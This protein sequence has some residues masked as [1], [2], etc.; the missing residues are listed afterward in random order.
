[1]RGVKRTP[2]EYEQFEELMDQAAYWMIWIG[3]FSSLLANLSNPAS[4]AAERAVKV[5][6]GF[7]AGCD[8]IEELMLRHWPLPEQGGPGGYFPR[9]YRLNLEPGPNRRAEC[10]FELEEHLLAGRNLALLYAWCVNAFKPVGRAYGFD[11]PASRRF[12]KTAQK[13]NVL[14]G[15]LE[16]EMLRQHRSSIA[17]APPDFWPP[18]EGAGWYREAYY[19]KT[20]GAELVSV[21]SNSGPRWH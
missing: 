21:E 10:P 9:G 15:R 13:V 3:E 2:L 17:G 19:S 14:R 20:D 4:V 5:F 6:K 16:D 12:L 11:Q 7:V 18:F 8:R 1:M